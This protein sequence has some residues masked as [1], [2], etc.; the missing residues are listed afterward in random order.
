VLGVF[1]PTGRVCVR[2]LDTEHSQVVAANFMVVLGP[3]DRARFVTR[4]T[5]GGRPCALGELGDAEERE[6]MVGLARL[7]APRVCGCGLAAVD[8]P[9]SRW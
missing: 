7:H 8:W 1:S 4:L 9:L 6:P 2:G 5:P 3:F